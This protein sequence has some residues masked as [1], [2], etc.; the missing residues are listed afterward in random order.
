MQFGKQILNYQEEIL[1]DLKELVAIPSVVGKPEPDMPFGKLPAAALQKILTRAK[2]MGLQTAN[3]DNY[4]GHAEYGTGADSAAVLVHIDVVPAGECW[5]TDPFTTILRDNHLYGRGVA[6][7]KGAAVVA[8]YCLKALKDAGVETQ[9][10]LRVIFG[11]GEEIASNDLE[12]YFKKQEMPVFAFTPDSEYGICNREK[13]ILRLDLIVEND[14]TVV[15]SFDAGTVVNAVP[16]HAEATINCSAEQKETL[17]TLVQKDSSTFSSSEKEDGLHISAK[18]LSC[19]AMQPQEGKNAAAHLALLLGKVFSNQE[20][21]SLLTFIKNTIGL[22]TNGNSLKVRQ[23]DVQSGPLTLNLGILHMDNRIS[24]AG[25]DI[26][27]PVTSDGKA[28]AKSITAT[29]AGYG[30]ACKI[31]GNSEPLFIPEDAPFIELL[32]E[33]YSHVMGENP[34]LYATGGGTYARELHGRGV[35]FGPFFPEE[36]D[37]RL[38]NSNENIDLT[39]FMKHAEICME[40]MYLMATKP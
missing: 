18:G 8:L 5:D 25:I 14:S 26:R 31:H 36:G 33:G 28:L 34:A 15:T 39:Y 37:R 4:A 40:T 17:K 10:R 29:A 16:C 38:H 21:G 2:E 12:M 19:H 32:K 35:A 3:V 27:Y 20:L 22:E 30:I 13:G 1:Q 6:D 11:S 24:S 9:R 7:D 23:S